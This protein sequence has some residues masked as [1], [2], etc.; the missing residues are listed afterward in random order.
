MVLD[1][2]YGYLEA[3]ELFAQRRLVFPLCSFYFAADFI[4]PKVRLLPLVDFRHRMID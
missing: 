4:L 3:K 2:V 1:Y